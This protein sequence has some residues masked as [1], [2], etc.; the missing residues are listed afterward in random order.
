MSAPLTL[1][2]AIGSA[3]TREAVREAIGKATNVTWTAE[4][5][6]WQQLQYA[7]RGGCP[8]ILLLSSYLPGLP[9]G[10]TLAS[11]ARV[12]L[13]TRLLVVF[14]P[15]TP[16]ERVMELLALHPRAIVTT[17]TTLS[18]LLKIIELVAK[19][20]L[21]YPYEY[22]Q[23]MATVQTIAT[24]LPLYGKG[25]SPRERELLQLLAQGL[26]EK[27]I[28]VRLGIGRRTIHTYLERVRHKLGAA[29]RV[30]AVALAT[31]AQFISPGKLKAA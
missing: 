27:E 31:A 21:I 5:S 20:M 9:T 19:G 12:L 22:M 8:D 7:L 16:L 2:V 18:D 10:P 6:D 14:R 26:S 28:A 11:F 3:V 4:A 24:M 30:H 23:R 29:N 13:Q 15:D 17:E 25:L 1:L